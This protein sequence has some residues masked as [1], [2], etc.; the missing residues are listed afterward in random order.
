M[1][2]SACC[3]SG[4][5]NTSTRLRLG[6]LGRSTSMPK[7]NEFEWNNESETFRFVRHV[8]D[9][10]KAKELIRTK[11]PRD[12]K[13]MD[14]EGVADLVGEPPIAGSMRLHAGIR[15][16]WVRVMTDEVDSNFP[17]ILVP[18]NDSYLPI[19]GWHRIA[20]AKLASRAKVPCVVLNK[21]E[22]KLVKIA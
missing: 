17:V 5:K 18:F 19:D 1:A 16:N 11:K 7:S 12:V 8:F 9:V 10:Q 4:I 15:I 20:K 21:S 6:R 22:S 3:C 14:I 13:E 2:A